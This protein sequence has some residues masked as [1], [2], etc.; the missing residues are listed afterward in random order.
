MK[1]RPSL[2]D[3][4]QRGKKILLT[5]GI[6]TAVLG[7]SFLF[8]GGVVSAATVG[9]SC[10]SQAKC[11]NDKKYVLECPSLTDPCISN[12]SCIWK[13]GTDCVGN[14]K[15]CVSD[16]MSFGCGTCSAANKCPTGY[17]CNKSGECVEEPAVE[18]DK[19]EAIKKV[20]EEIE[21]QNTEEP[22][23]EDT[24]LPKTA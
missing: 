22:K 2:S 5:V 17:D 3:S 20:K 21:I 11:S 8:G 19:D 6:L 23:P 13:L 12:M 16:V 7:G 14:K 18:E 24:E 15:T 4:L 1:I 10:N 9:D